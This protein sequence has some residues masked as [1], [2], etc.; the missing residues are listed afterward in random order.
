MIKYSIPLITLTLVLFIMYRGLDLDPTVVPS[1][2]IDKPVPVFSLPSLLD[3]DTVITNNSFIDQVHLINVWATW[4]VGCRI[5]HDFLNTITSASGIPILGLNWRDSQS[6]ALLWLDNLGN[7]Y[8]DTAFDPDGKVSIDF[9]V[10]GAP[11]TY[12]IRSDGTIAYKHIA[13]LTVD[14]WEGEF[15]PRITDLCGSYPCRN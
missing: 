15:I 9:G 13:P 8:I 10:Y 11:E 5:E 14:V 12:L 4:C 1:P 2:L 7:P 3:S 6:E